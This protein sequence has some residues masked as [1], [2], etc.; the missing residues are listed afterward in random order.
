MSTISDCEDG[1]SESGGGDT[2]ARQM[3][4]VKTLK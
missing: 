2:H 1:Y 4:V 3:V